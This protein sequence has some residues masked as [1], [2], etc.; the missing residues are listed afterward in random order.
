[1]RRT[2]D[3]YDAHPDAPSRAEA[4]LDAEM[5]RRY[6]VWPEDKRGTGWNDE[7]D[8]PPF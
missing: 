3:F 4:D 5:E 6:R 2:Q 1:M 8:A 7:Y